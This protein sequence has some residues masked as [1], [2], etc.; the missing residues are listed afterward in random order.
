MCA[1]EA[2]LVQRFNIYIII[3]HRAIQIR[4]DRAEP[5]NSRASKHIFQAKQ[6]WICAQD[7]WSLRASFPTQMQWIN[8][9]L[10]QQLK[11]SH[12]KEDHQNRWV[13]CSICSRKKILKILEIENKAGS[14]R[15]WLA[16]PRLSVVGTST[17]Y[18][19]LS[20][21]LRM[22]KWLKKHR[23][24]YVWR[25][26]IYWPWHKYSSTCH[27]S[28]KELVDVMFWEIDNDA[29]KRRLVLFP[30]SML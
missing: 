5:T 30:N 13:A 20:L 15:T 8:Y 22:H 24:T 17:W 6:F 12:Q 21:Q 16:C 27:F 9:R 29:R 1:S 10:M 23:C 7:I 26:I 2:H 28:I 11:P 18:T 3:M 19:F 4:T 25:L 14:L